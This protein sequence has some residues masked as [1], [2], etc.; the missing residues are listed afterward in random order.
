MGYDINN[1]AK[2][3][4]S[5]KLR[6]ITGVTGRL[7]SNDPQ[8]SYL[9]EIQIIGGGILPTLG[10]LLDNITLFS[11]SINIPQSTIDP[12]VHNYMG[13]RIFY[14]GKDASPK[15]LI[16]TFWDDEALTVYSYMNQWYSA[17]HDDVT[18]DIV[19]EAQYRRE[20]RIKLKDASDTVNTGVIILD[21][22]FPID[23]AEIPMT[24]E[25][26]DA[27][28]VTVTFQYNTKRLVT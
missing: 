11:K 3:L 2:R 18:G 27:I 15:T 21:G 26:S 8:R 10:R 25:T 28:E 7:L 23:I 6:E 5:K 13:E 4:A 22:V 20:F 19:D 16:A 24:Y 17:I 9:W 14:A 12:I 1:I